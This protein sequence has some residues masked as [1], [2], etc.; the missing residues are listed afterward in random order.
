MSYKFLRSYLILLIGAAR[1]D[2]IMDGLE[3]NA[4]GYKTKQSKPK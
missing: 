3:E 4:F 1:E 2:M